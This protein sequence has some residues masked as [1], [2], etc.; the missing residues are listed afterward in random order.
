MTSHIV[1]RMSPWS[2][3][4]RGKLRRYNHM[5]HRES[6]KRPWV[7]H[8]AYLHPTKGY[9]M[10]SKKRLVAQSMMREMALKGIR[11]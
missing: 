6:L 4:K 3:L 10:I 5:L 7:T 9:R 1:N 11:A 8:V 2:R